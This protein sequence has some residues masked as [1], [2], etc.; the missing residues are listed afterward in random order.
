VEA[1]YLGAKVYGVGPGRTAGREGGVMGPPDDGNVDN[2]YAG[3]GVG[4][5]WNVVVREKRT[6]LPGIAKGGYWCGGTSTPS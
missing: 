1:R 5:E 6:C 4:G 2:E 3:D